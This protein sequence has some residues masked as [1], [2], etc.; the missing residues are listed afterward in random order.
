[1]EDEIRRVQNEMIDLGEELGDRG[2]WMVFTGRR[3]GRGNASQR[4]G[5]SH[6]ATAR[7]TADGA[8]DGSGGGD[9]GGDDGAD[10]DLGEE[11]DDSL[12]DETYGNN[13]KKYFEGEEED[14]GS[15][16][17]SSESNN[18]VNHSKNTDGDSNV[19]AESDAN[20]THKHEG[21]PGYELDGVDEG[22][23]SPGED[24]GDTPENS[25]GNPQDL[26][27]VIRGE[28]NPGLNTSEKK[29]G[30]SSGADVIQKSR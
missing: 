3:G 30:G 9:D 14:G 5:G 16:T 19:S 7:G 15:N 17:N 18:I 11:L 20:R 22:P 12:I 24:G 8:V 21:S 6:S 2:R 4:G 29:R 23:G 26:E 28:R 10:I 1:V 27:A 13:K 25:Q